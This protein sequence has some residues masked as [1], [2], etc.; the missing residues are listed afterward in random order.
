MRLVFYLLATA[1][2][3]R[4]AR[5]IRETTN[6]V[7]D[8]V[9]RLAEDASGAE[10]EWAEFFLNP[11]HRDWPLDRAVA[12]FTGMREAVSRN[13][14]A[15]AADGRWFASWGR[16]EEFVEWLDGAIEDLRSEAAGTL[17]KVDVQPD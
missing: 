13:G 9:R 6:D 17:F 5:I 3:E 10:P 2:G 14:A 8:S 1:P 15:W 16:P 11:N 7:F 12:A 4:E